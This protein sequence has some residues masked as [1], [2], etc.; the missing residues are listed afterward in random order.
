MRQWSMRRRLVAVSL[1][2]A[3]IS[4]VVTV[5]LTLTMLSAGAHT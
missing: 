2:L 1:W 5:A 4:I 3:L